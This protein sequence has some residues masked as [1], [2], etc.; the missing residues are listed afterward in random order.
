M[1]DTPPPNPPQ[2]HPLL[3][4]FRT[5]FPELGARSVVS[6]TTECASAW[7]IPASAEGEPVSARLVYVLAPFASDALRDRFVAV[8]ER[9]H[10]IE[11][12]GIVPLID[13]GERG[14]YPY[15]TYACPAGTTLRQLFDPKTKKIEGQKALAIGKGL[16][17][18]VAFLHAAG[19]HHGS[20]HPDNIIIDSKGD[21]WL[22]SSALEMLFEHPPE[23]RTRRY[24]GVPASQR[25]HLAPEQTDPSVTSPSY[26][27]DIY[28]LGSVIYTMLTGGQVGGFF[29]LPSKEAD[30]AHEIDDIVTS[31]LQPK[32][33][34]RNFDAPSLYAALDNVRTGYFLRDVEKKKLEDKAASKSAPASSV[35]STHDLEGRTLWQKHRMKI[36]A[37]AAA[38]LVALGWWSYENY[39]RPPT[40]I[41][42]ILAE[43]QGHI[44]LAE[45]VEAMQKINEAFE[46]AGV[47]PQKLKTIVMFLVQNGMPEDAGD[48]LKRHLGKMD[49]DDEDVLAALAFQKAFEVDLAAYKDASLQA[50]A[51]LDAGDDK[52]ER[53]ALNAAQS[54][55]PGEPDVERR[56]AVNPIEIEFRLERA[57]SAVQKQLPSG[58]K[59]LH[60]SSIVRSAAYLDLS[61]NP[62]LTSLEPL[63]GVRINEL[64][65]SGT[66]V[67]DLAPL[68][69]MLLRR[70]WLDD[71]K[72]TSL[73]PISRSLL[74]SLAFENTPVADLAP[75]ANLQHLQYLRHTAPEDGSRVAQITPPADNNFWENA[76]GMRFQRL[77]EYPDIFFATTELKVGEFAQFIAESGHQ[78]APAQAVSAE[79]E[80]ESTVS[81]DDSLLAPGTRYSVAGLSAD[82]ASAFCSW[83][84]ARDR[85]AGNIPPTALYRM[86][87]DAEWG[88]AAS[89]SEHPFQQPSARTL[90]GRPALFEKD[91]PLRIPASHAAGIGRYSGLIAG[92]REWSG[93]PYEDGFPALS[94]RGGSSDVSLTAP[95]LAPE[96]IAEP[97]PNPATGSSTEAAMP[98]VPSTGF[99]APRVPIPE[100]TPEG[101]IDLRDRIALAPDVRRSDIGVRV[102]LSLSPNRGLDPIVQTLESGEDISEAVER[103][104]ALINLS[105]TAS[106]EADIN[107]RTLDSAKSLVVYADL[108]EAYK[109]D[110]RAP[111]TLRRVFEYYKGRRYLHLKVPVSFDTAD[112]LA[113]AVGG[114]LVTLTDDGE[115]DWVSEIV[116]PRGTL[117]P[118]SI[119]L[120]ATIDTSVSPIYSWGGGISTNLPD[121]VPFT[122]D[123]RLLLAPFP[124]PT[125]KAPSS[126]DPD[127]TGETPLPA[128]DA[129]ERFSAGNPPVYLDWHERPRTERH[130]FLIEWG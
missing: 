98:T 86:P 119:W 31:C 76:V 64:D 109:K 113:R 17:R 59:L 36:I 103:A 116:L 57:L 27:S 102:V 94:V 107:P 16:V 85:A 6:A 106:L 50:S 18:S 44:S 54:A 3:A 60:N 1:S 30:L 47:D 39:M 58:V 101:K 40:P 53:L 37:P 72:V 13:A 127:G 11:T 34:D 130:G 25:A 68:E 51:A 5:L 62:S 70:L 66:S 111:S 24:A 122:P 93:S 74:E 95:P 8:V 46:A 10:K 63:R 45:L 129:F 120:G 89:L 84:T 80:E 105:Q 97:N 108:R 4:T 69:N 21:P 82:D 38:A 19:I 77:A 55:L 115:L 126:A 96:P 117:P 92:V 32:P 118:T 121:F 12:P 81:W 100:A 49:P 73:E 65:I 125:P 35:Y 41:A 26:K 42:P 23:I 61:S 124:A 29:K 9:L 71:T 90:E 110:R 83:L 78:V 128:P 67:S 28:A 123:H 7:C 52:A 104:R 14:G 99:L 2:E 56:L 79:G 112:R 91:P 20:I 22:I 33:E 114:H 87:T 43:A 75:A 15:L 48:L 88:S